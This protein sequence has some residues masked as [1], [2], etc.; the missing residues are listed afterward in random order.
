MM[1]DLI[2]V[3]QSLPIVCNLSRMDKLRMDIADKGTIGL[4]DSIRFWVQ[5]DQFQ[6]MQLF[7]ANP[8]GARWVG[9]SRGMNAIDPKGENPDRYQWRT[10]AR[11]ERKAWSV[12][13]AIPFRTLGI[14]PPPATRFLRINVG[15]KQGPL[16]ERELSCWAPS[17]KGAGDSNPGDFGWL[18]FG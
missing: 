12:T 13:L 7:E 8:G 4:D 9:Q 18:F 16:N 10:G 11:R 1:A 15:R 6:Q 17:R 2:E 14:R 5:A 3:N